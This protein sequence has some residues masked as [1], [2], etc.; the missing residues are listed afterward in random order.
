MAIAPDSS[1]NKNARP[2]I[3]QVIFNEKFAMLK[4]TRESD[5][6]LNFLTPNKS[7]YRKKRT[8]IFYPDYSVS[9]IP[10]NTASEYKIEYKNRLN[11]KDK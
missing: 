7:D 3:G 6:K 8:E 10:S 4:P 11:N 5:Y 9:S 1:F 2:N